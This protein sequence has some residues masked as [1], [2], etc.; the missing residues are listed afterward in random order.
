MSGVDLQPYCN[1]IVP[2]SG[3][4]MEFLGVRKAKFTKKQRV[5]N[6]HNQAYTACIYIFSHQIKNKLCIPYFINIWPFLLWWFNCL[7]KIPIIFKLN[8]AH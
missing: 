1:F 8:I 6:I 3:T 4:S 7:Y 5:L 2:T